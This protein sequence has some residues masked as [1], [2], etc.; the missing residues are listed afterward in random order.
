[1]ED[2]LAIGDNW[3]DLPMLEAAGSAV[4]MSNAPEDLKRLA[5]T[6]GWA[7]G[8]SNDHDGVAEALEAVMELAQNEPLAV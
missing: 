2:V 6:R 7:I 3:N 8:P 1:M 4:L 5:E